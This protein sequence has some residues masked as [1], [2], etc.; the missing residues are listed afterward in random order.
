MTIS[1]DVSL[2]D[3]TL[4]SKMIASEASE[5]A[6]VIWGVSFDT[7]LEDEMKITIIAT[8]FEKKPEQ[9][10]VPAEKKAAPA[11]APEVRTIPAVKPTATV[12]E[13]KVEAK[14]AEQPAPEPVKEEKKTV[15]ND[16][17]FD[18]LFDDFFKPK[19]RK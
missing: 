12:V 4:A 11:P 8:G 5:D 17:D 2:E 14:P 7:D 15:V 13:P 6:N 1:P 9:Q 10:T 18:D 19:N 16:D 3:A